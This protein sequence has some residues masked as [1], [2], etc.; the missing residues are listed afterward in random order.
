MRSN[1]EGRLR[2]GLM[3]NECEGFIERNWKKAE[4]R[5]R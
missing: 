4:G 1:I 3:N 5:G 2:W